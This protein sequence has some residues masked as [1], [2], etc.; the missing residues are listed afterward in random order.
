[1]TARSSPS[2]VS[3]HLGCLGQGHGHFG[4]M[5]MTHILIKAPELGSMGWRPTST[6]GQR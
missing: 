4:E 2:A 5:Q 1:M 6:R 3:Q